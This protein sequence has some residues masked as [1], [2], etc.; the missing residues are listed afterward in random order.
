[1]AVVTH[2]WGLEPVHQKPASMAKATSSDSNKSAQK[3]RHYLP[4]PSLSRLGSGLL[5]DLLLVLL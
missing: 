4:E 2:H 1:M 5:L 3:T